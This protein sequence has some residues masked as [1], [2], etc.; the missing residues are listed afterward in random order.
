MSCTDKTE[1]CTQEKQNQNQCSITVTKQTE[2]PNKNYIPD[3]KAAVK[4]AS[5]AFAV[6]ENPIYYISSEINVLYKPKINC[7]PYIRL[8]LQTKWNHETGCL[9]AIS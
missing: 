1:R 2:D 3:A 5:V 6:V 9:Q 4:G 8:L 7:S